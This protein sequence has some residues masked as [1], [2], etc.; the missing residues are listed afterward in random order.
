MRIGRAALTAS[1]A[2][3]ATAGV[4]VANRLGDLPVSTLAATP[5][6]IG[7]GRLWLI[8]SSGLLADRP[9]IPSLVGFWIV[10]IAV[11]VICSVRVV[12]GAAIAGHT[13]SAFGVYGI[14]GL[15]RLADPDAFASMMRVADYGLSA[16][17]AAWLGATARVLWARYPTRLHH[18]LI[19][20]GSIAC[21]GI[22]LAFRP[23]VT[24]LD[25]EH[26]LAYA[27]GIALADGT[28]TRRL[29]YP[30]R[31]IAAAMAGLLLATRGS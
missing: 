31:R 25:S 22:G 10:A 20:V 3:G 26:I 8:P 7:D 24:F 12:V 1:A 30:T 19:A 2:T 13:L 23:D 4:T 14:I 17:I 18:G 5:R 16:I 6:V 15:A 28:V 27:I 29:V 9:A 11:L 21:A